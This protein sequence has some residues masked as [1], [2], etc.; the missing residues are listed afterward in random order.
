MRRVLRPGGKIG[1][2]VWCSIED[3]P[4][5]LALA[6]ALNRVLGRDVGD[7]YKGGPWGL[8]E[9]SSLAQLAHDSGFTNVEVGKYEL[10]IVFEGGPGQLLLTTSSDLGGSD[11]VQAFS[12]KPDSARLST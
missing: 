3:C 2:A 1:I 4:P 5:F 6:N 12:D 8:A 7:A 10:P 11:V 9:S